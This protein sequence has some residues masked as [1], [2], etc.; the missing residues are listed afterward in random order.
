MRRFS[1][2]G[3]ACVVALLAGACGGAATVTPDGS[4]PAGEA[5]N[6]VDPL[7]PADHAQLGELLLS[8]N[9][10]ADALR[11][12]TVLLALDP[13]DPAAAHLGAARALSAAGEAAPARR[14]LL[15]ALEIAPHF[16]PAQT[17]LLQLRGESP[18]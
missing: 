16:R 18:P 11:E 1:L 7:A 15:Q 2:A 10:P 14:H 12:Y 8:A 13:Q 6:L 9:R 5:V 3:I 4:A 17:L